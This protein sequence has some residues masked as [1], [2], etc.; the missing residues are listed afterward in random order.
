[1]SLCIYVT[2]LLEADTDSSKYDPGDSVAPAKQYS[3]VYSDVCRR[4]SLQEVKTATRN[5]DKQLIIATRGSSKVYKG[6]IDDSTR[7][8]VIKRLNSWTYEA[9]SKFHTQVRI[10]SKLRH[11]NL[12]PLIGYCNEKGERALI[13]S[14]MLHGTLRNHL[15]GSSNPPLT[16]KRRLQ[17]CF[18]IA[19]GL[20]YLHNRYEQFIFHGGI[21][22]ANI[23]LDEEWVA[24][25]LDFGLS[26]VCPSD[27]DLTNAVNGRFSDLDK[28]YFKE[29]KVAEKFDV[30]S[31]GV[32]L[33]EVLCARPPVAPELPREQVNL[34]KWATSC[35]TEGKLEQIVDSN[36]KGHIGPECLGKFV[37]TAIAC[38]RDQDTDRP[39]MEGVMESL[40]LAM[41]LQEAAAIDE[42]RTSSSF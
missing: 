23:F 1:M 26:E 8:V 25:L 6:L 30:C 11:R 36:L 7:A 29:R 19:E 37:E 40:E 39:A 10:L 9:A 22:S 2:A 14:Y 4:F 38:I 13:H 15:Y 12:V 34:V 3:D 41:H 5:F 17:I 27:P 35:F 18:G 24:K 31:F 32:L 42:G 28:E 21:K 16:W 33:L 20:D